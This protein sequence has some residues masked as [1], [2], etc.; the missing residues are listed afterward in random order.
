M[1]ICDLSFNPLS[2]KPTKWSNTLNLSYCLS[3]IDHF[4]GLALKGSK[5]MYEK[6]LKQALAFTK[7]TKEHSH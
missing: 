5:E 2:A 4:A 6:S 3:V 1:I 7:V